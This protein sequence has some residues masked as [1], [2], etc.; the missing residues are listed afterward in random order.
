MARPCNI[1]TASKVD[2]LD[3]CP[4]TMSTSQ[5]AASFCASMRGQLE[6]FWPGDL[7][8]HVVHFGHLAAFAACS[9]TRRTERDA[10]HWSCDPIGHRRDESWNATVDLFVAGTFFFCTS[11]RLSLLLV[12]SVWLDARPVR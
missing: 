4:G 7:E 5:G 12:D 10:G 1:A 9:Q 8:K 2:P 3:T 6:I 11:L